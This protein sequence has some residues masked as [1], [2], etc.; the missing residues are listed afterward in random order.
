M[1]ATST[2]YVVASVVGAAH[3]VRGGRT[4]RFGGVRLPGSPLLHA[5]TIG[6]PLSAPPVMVAAMVWAERRDRPDV[7]RALAALFVVGILGEVD[8]WSTLAHP[9][10]SPFTTALVALDLILTISIQAE[11]RARPSAA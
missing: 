3:S 8:T 4:A 10:R 6:T 5:L 2:A 9:R 1:R 7:T 11:A